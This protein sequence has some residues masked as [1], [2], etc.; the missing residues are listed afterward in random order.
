MSDSSS[1]SSVIICPRPTPNPAWLQDWTLEAET[2][3]CTDG[4][5]YITIGKGQLLYKGVDVEL[6]DEACAPDAYSCTSATFVSS[7][8]T[9][10]KYAFEGSGVICSRNGTTG[11][12]ICI[13]TIRPLRLINMWNHHNHALIRKVFPHSLHTNKNTTCQ[14]TGN[15]LDCDPLA[16]SFRFHNNKWHRPQGSTDRVFVSWFQE[17]GAPTDRNS[18]QICTFAFSR[19]VCGRC[20]KSATMAPGMVS[21]L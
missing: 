16:L 10:C 17:Y 15:P 13:E 8:A 7:V 11:K 14:F 6:P 18:M 21:Q 12:V 1:S 2:Q 9:A 4:F 5:A 3:E 20:I 19:S